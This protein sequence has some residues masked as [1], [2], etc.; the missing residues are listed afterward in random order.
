MSG[1]VPKSEHRGAERTFTKWRQNRT[2][3][4]ARWKGNHIF[5]FKSMF[6]CFALFC[7]QHTF[8]AFRWC[9]TL[10]I[11]LLHRSSIACVASDRISIK[12]RFCAGNI[13]AWRQNTHNVAS[14]M[15][16]S[17]HSIRFSCRAG[18]ETT[19]RLNAAQNFLFRTQV[20]LCFTQ[21]LQKQDDL[22]G[23]GFYWTKPS[24]LESNNFTFMTLL[25]PGTGCLLDL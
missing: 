5:T 18:N 10:V 6:C 17:W 22:G 12:L 24:H 2:N 11:D 8:I 7:S 4:Y 16:R 13:Q 25:P 9:S 3:Y 1:H 15:E 20:C 23:H 19:T 14:T 21:N